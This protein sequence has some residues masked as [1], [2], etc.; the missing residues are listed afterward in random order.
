MVDQDFADQHAARIDAIAS[1]FFEQLTQVMDAVRVRVTSRL[2]Q[3][4]AIEGGWVQSNMQNSA[5]IRSM[6]T[7]FSEELGSSNYHAVVAAFVST[8]SLQID[9]FSSAYAM[10]QEKYPRLRGLFTLTE[11]D[12]GVLADQA[13]AA[14]LALETKSLEATSALR[15]L[16]SKSLGGILVSDLIE[17]VSGI[18]R[19]VAEVE[20][21]GI[22]Q[23]TTFFRLVGN[24]VY[25]NIEKLGLVI[26]YKLFGIRDSRNRSFC[27]ALLDAN[28]LYTRAE[29]DLMD[30]G[31]IPGVF[32]N[33]GG[34]GCRHWFTLWDIR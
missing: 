8:L 18:I 22:D 21:M 16:S 19:K 11:S 9:E 32:D 29:I 33:V 20:Q 25:S 4:L 7:M 5:V 6:D 13:G 24:L 1:N 31:Q 10:A 28:K 3:E 23:L 26:F 34:Y 14:L 27:A 30:N 17:V 2:L 15:T 12:A